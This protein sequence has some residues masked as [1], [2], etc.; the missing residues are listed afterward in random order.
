M[1]SYFKSICTFCNHEI[2][3]AVEMED[4][5]CGI[6]L[7]INM[8]CASSSHFP[9]LYL[10]SF[11]QEVRGLAYYLKK[12]RLPQLSLFLASNTSCPL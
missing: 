6:G 9:K 7:I 10:L 3:I 4:F 12:K 5:I 8:F 2:S 11:G 1:S